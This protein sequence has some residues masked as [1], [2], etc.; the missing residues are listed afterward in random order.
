MSVPN[1]QLI[2]M[3]LLVCECLFGL[4]VPRC[5]VPCL[6]GSWSVLSPPLLGVG[7]GRGLATR[8]CLPSATDFFEGSQPDAGGPAAVG[9]KARHGLEESPLPSPAANAPLCVRDEGKSDSWSAQIGSWRRGWPSPRERATSWWSDGLSHG[10][11][12]C[13]CS[14]VVVNR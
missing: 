6:P 3:G 8:G 7:G 12:V 10:L 4:R 2:G 13:W 1:C 14:S 11:M 9:R 5:H